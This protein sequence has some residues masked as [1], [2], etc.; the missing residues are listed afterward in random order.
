MRIGF[1]IS[2]IFSVAS[3]AV[4]VAAFPFALRAQP[5]DLESTRLPISKVDSAWRF[6]IGDDARWAQPG[7]DDSH[8]PTLQPANDWTKQGYPKD[9]Q[10]AWFRFHLRA[11]AHTQSLV[12]ELPT[13]EK[14]YQLFSDGRLVAQVGALP[15]GPARN[16]IGAPRV[17]TL[18]VNS[19]SSAKE[20]TIALRLWQ[21]VSIAGSRSSRL[22]G[23]A[24]AGDPETVLQQ[25]A[26]TK[27]VNLL[28][29]G[30]V[31][32]IDIIL[33]IVG[34]ATALLFWL[35]RERFYLWLLVTSSSKLAFTL[36]ILPPNTRR[37]VFISIPIS[38]S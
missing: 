30:G 35:T 25:F 37:G 31:Y 11:P 13:I 33:L 21:D 17:F 4:F 36:P 28:A 7:F 24:Y 2:K 1:S 6:H 23:E 19:G 20:I 8:W 32:T 34:A 5:I 9:T 3:A 38:T 22:E 15:P 12:L 14:S 18:A 10:L 27:A 29:T 16:V 26:A